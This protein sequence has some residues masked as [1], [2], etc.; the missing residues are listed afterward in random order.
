MDSGEGLP[1]GDAR[2]LIAN[3]AVG[4]EIHNLHLDRVLTRVQ[5]LPGFDAVRGGPQDRVE[6][7]SIDADLCDLTH[8]AEIKNQSV[9]RARTSEIHLC[10][11]DAST[12]GQQ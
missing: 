8:I 11:H 7:C 12:P 10:S 2:L 1:R 4:P 5:Q 9:R 6:L 3:Q